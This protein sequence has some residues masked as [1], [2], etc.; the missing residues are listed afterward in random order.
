MLYMPR[1][2]CYLRFGLYDSHV[3][4]SGERRGKGERGRERGE[5]QLYVR[6]QE[7][8]DKNERDRLTPL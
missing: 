5:E 6:D 7:K 3:D 8:V 2:S 1:I 4:D